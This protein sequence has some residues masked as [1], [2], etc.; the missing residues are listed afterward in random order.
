M[1][2]LDEAVNA[3]GLRKKTLLVVL[4]KPEPSEEEL[5]WKKGAVV[6]RQQP[7]NVWHKPECNPLQCQACLLRCYPDKLAVA[8]RH[9]FQS[10]SP[11][12]SSLASRLSWCLMS[13]NLQERCCQPSMPIWPA[14]I[15]VCIEH[16]L[17]ARGR[18]I[19][20]QNGQAV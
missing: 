9:T 13:G 14:Q 2:C 11:T 10:A 7:E 4:L 19:S 17:Q 18:T 3:Q 8:Q 1:W 15:S 5:M 6:L 20:M 16:V 12:H